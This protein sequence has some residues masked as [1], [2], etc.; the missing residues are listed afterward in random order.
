MG[1]AAE[2]AAELDAAA[3]AALP[4]AEEAPPSRSRPRSAHLHVLGT[5]RSVEE[6]GELCQGRLG[7]RGG[8][9]QWIR[10]RIG[11]HLVGSGGLR[12]LLTAW[13]ARCR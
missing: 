1:G 7:R 10:R 9:G 6:G 12:R 2:L 3:L 8:A 13:Q 5:A 11:R 4:P